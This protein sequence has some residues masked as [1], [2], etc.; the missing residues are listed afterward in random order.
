[1]AVK[2]S[3]D[4]PQDMISPDGMAD[5]SVDPKEQE[6]F[7]AMA[8]LWWDPQGPMRPL[9]RINP[10]RLDY[11]RDQI[12]ENHPK[13]KSTQESSL[14]P[15]QAKPLQGL[16]CLDIGCGAGLVSESLARMGGSVLGLDAT[17]KIIEAAKAHLANSMDKL[18]LSYQ[19][20][21]VESLAQKQLQYDIVTALEVVEHVQNPDQFLKDVAS[22][23][24]PGGLVFLSTLNR[25]AKSFA[26]GIIAAEYILRWLPR[27]THEWKRF[28]KPAELVRSLRDCGLQPLN[29]SGITYNPFK[30]QF[31]ISATDVSVNYILCFQ[32]TS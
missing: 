14:K 5:G 27:G 30:D 15:V 29:L 21:T 18:D 9:H 1:M 7:G 26:L 6:K 23:V 31:S 24:K 25:T 11:I 12:L 8:A 19:C 3:Q 22:V 13:F 10:L 4:K 17:A 2:K 20:G 16:S 28:M 32:K